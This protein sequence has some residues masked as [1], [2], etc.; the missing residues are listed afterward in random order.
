MRTTYSVV[1]LGKLG[2]S[3]AAAIAMRG[4][5]VI[6]VDVNR[7]VVEAINCAKAPVLE[8]DLAQTILDAG[9]RL[10]A[11]LSYSEAIE[12]SDITFVIVPTPSDS[13]G[14]FSL[15]YAGEA[16]KQ[17]GRSLRQKSNYH[18][19]VLTST[20]LPGSTRFSL[21]PLLEKESGKVCGKDFGLC[22]SPEFIALGSV[23]RDFLNPDFTLI[24]EFDEKSGSILESCYAEILENSPPCQRMSIENA[25]VAKLSLNSYVTMK[26]S[27][28]NM[29]ADV[30]ERIPGGNV[31]VVT[32]A[33]G[34]DSRIGEKYLKGALGYGGPCFPRD[35]KALSFLAKELGVSV[36]L[37]EVVDLYNRE[38]A[39]N[40]AAKIQCF[41]QSEMTIA[42]LG[43]AYKPLSNVIEE[44]QGI[45][46]ARCLSS[47]VRKVVVFDPLA[48]ENAAAVFSGVNIEVSESLPQCLACAQV[49]IIA[50][51]DPVFKGLKAADILGDKDHVVVLDCWRILAHELR[52]N[53]RIR[54]LSL[55][56]NL[57]SKLQQT[58]FDF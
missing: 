42:V 5:S 25:E 23:I 6:G 3:I 18:L 27:F 21:L 54:Y 7:D 40:T 35:N 52:G 38:L 53:D 51:P 9:S 33:L 19:V 26:I 32:N 56:V 13:R 8:T 30:C 36:P 58:Q 43:L 55:G 44:S 39:Q 31:D 20:V 34:K 47:R 48:N 50:T 57:A 17:I 12:N 11:T 2:S 16:F 10:R 15:K 29:L 14:A 37:A 45:A 4:F 24:G 28:A 41:L 46:L 49:V 22:Y 1:G